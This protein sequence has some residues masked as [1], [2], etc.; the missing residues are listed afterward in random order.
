LL[1][2]TT[3]IRILATTGG[4][5]S[6]HA[7]SI[8]SVRLLPEVLRSGSRYAAV[9]ATTPSCAGLGPTGELPGLPVISPASRSRHLPRFDHLPLECRR[10]PCAGRPTACMHPTSSAVALAIVL[11]SK[12]WRLRSHCGPEHSVSGALGGCESRRYGVLLMFAAPSVA[13]L[14]G[15]PTSTL[16]RRAAETCTSGLSPWESPPQD[17]G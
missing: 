6:T 2:P 10:H 15:P 4:I 3:P 11:A 14:P 5:I 17:A 12:T 13:S 7:L 16:S 9:I 8:S 1:P